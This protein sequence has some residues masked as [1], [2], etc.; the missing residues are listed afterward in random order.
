[1]NSWSGVSLKC[2][3]WELEKC[4]TW[5]ESEAEGDWFTVLRED[6]IA[7]VNNYLLTSALHLYIHVYD[8][9]WTCTEVP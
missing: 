5:L 6:E 7:A 3:V 4:Q 8:K 2:I 1:M 9:L